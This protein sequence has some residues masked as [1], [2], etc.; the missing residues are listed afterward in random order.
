MEL[1]GWIIA[2]IVCIAIGANI[3]AIWTAWVL[4]AL[5][6]LVVW[7]VAV[8]IRVGAFDALFGMWW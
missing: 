8:C 6:G 2:G 3:G 1:F 5:I 4:G 7:L